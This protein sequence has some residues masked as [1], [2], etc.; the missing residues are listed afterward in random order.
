MD[1]SRMIKVTLQ[2]SSVLGL[3]IHSALM[4]AITTVSLTKL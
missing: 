1:E 2:L 4:Q 3:Y